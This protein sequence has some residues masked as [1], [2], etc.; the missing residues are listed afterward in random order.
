MWVKGDSDLFLF[1][2]HIRPV[3]CVQ[4]EQKMECKRGHNYFCHVCVDDL[5]FSCLN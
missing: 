3:L 1:S 4:I 5:I 2:V